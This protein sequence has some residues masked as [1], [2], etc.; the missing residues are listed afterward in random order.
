MKRGVLPRRWLGM[1]PR[2]SRSHF[3][4]GGTGQTPGSN[5]ISLVIREARHTNFPCLR[6]ATRPPTR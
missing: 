5:L 2:P 1:P 4:I 6:L 3:W